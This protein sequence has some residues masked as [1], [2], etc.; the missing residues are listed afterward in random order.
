MDTK[1]IINSCSL[2]AKLVYGTRTKQWYLVDTYDRDYQYGIDPEDF[3]KMGEKL[4]RETY[5]AA[6]VI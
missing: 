3:D 5:L 4:A 2:R 1:I 6:S